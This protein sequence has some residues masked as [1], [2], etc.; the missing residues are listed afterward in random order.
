MPSVDEDGAAETA[1]QMVH[2]WTALAGCRVPIVCLSSDVNFRKHIWPAY[3]ANRSETVRPSA[4]SPTKRALA[5]RFKTF[6]IHGLEA[7]D[8]MGILATSDR[9]ASSVICSIDKDM[10]AVPATVFIPTKDM[11]PRRIRSIQADRWWM[12]QTLH[13]DPVDGYQGIPRVGPKTAEAI[14]TEAGLDFG[15]MWEAVVAAYEQRGLTLDDAIL[16][17]RLARI[18]RRPD[19]NREAE[20]ITLWHPTCPATLSL[21]S[22]GANPPPPGAETSRPPRRPSSASTRTP[23]AR[24]KARSPATSAS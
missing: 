22:L 7:D 5:A 8:V 12:M 15:A 21:A 9:Y 11:R 19:Y 3:K 24:A 4:L 1:I 20:E 17:A 14:L 13:G 23:R 10:A 18:L 6:T 16:T 2:A